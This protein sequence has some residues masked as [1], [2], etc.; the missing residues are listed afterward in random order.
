R[1]PENACTPL[2]CSASRWRSCL[3]AN[4]PTA[5][6]RCQATRRARVTSTARLVAETIHQRLVLPA[7]D[8]DHG[9]VDH[10]HE[11]RGEHDDEVRDLIHFSN[12]TPWGRGERGVFPPAVKKFSCARHGL[13]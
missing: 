7:I 2:S 4:S 11:W 12:A 6:P 3:Y 1:A 9:S 13:D 10:F 8:F 5:A